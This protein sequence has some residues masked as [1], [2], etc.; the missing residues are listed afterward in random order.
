M[1][2]NTQSEAAL[3]VCPNQAGKLAGVCRSI[4]FQEIREGRLQA[5][6]CGARTLI[7]RSD[8]ESWLARLPVV[9]SRER[10]ADE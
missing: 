5:R 1:A 3:A 8:L 6:K 10:L 4:I 7:R 9:A 2:E